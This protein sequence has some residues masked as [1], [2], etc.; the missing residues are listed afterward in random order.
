MILSASRRTDIPAFYSEWMA[1]RLTVGFCE[2]PNPFNPRQIARV[3]MHPDDVDAVVFWTRHARPVHP[4]LD[5][6]DARGCPYYFHYTITGYGPPAEPRAP[7]LETATRTFLELARRLPP[8]AVIWR[9]D[10]NLL[11]TAF[12][13]ASHRER[14][15]AI[16]ARLEGH[17]R[18]VVISVVHPYRKTRRRMAAQFVWGEE[19]CDTPLDHP[20]LPGLLLDLAA[21]A[22][23]HGMVIEACAQ[24]RDF[25]NLGISPTRCID[26]RLLG[27]LFGGSWPAGRDPGQ[28]G[29][30][31]CVASKDIGMVDT[32]TFGCAY[33]YSTVSDRVAARRQ[34]AHDP[35]AATLVP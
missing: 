19:L 25:S 17:A 5:I 7:S 2:V 23:D 13:P 6:L 29:E 33:C 22:R 35:R 20:D 15:G 27:E 3:S 32:C 30:C 8:G 18:R 28:R 21:T 4:V 1:H 10:P 9:Y 12:S 16:A 31:R 14:F 26:D 24:P 34:K 11:G